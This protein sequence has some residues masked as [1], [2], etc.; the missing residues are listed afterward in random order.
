[1]GFTKQVELAVVRNSG[2]AGNVPRNYWSIS[3]SLLTKGMSFREKD[4]GRA[5]REC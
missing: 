4:R 2:A 1:V 3:T 5:S